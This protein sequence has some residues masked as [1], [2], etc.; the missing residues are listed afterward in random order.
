MTPQ[1][2]Q[3]ERDAISA[4]RERYLASGKKITQLPS[5]AAPN[6]NSISFNGYGYQLIAEIET[7]KARSKKRK[8]T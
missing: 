3:P 1:S 4:A 7:A 6:P 5:F 2:R 8:S